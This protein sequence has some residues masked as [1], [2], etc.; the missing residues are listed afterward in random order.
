MN[1]GNASTLPQGIATR[2]TPTDPFEAHESLRSLQDKQ[3]QFNRYRNASTALKKCILNAVDDEYIKTLNLKITRYATVS[4]LKLLI[5]LWEIYGE[6]TIVD[7][8]S[9]ETRMKV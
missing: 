1:P 4:S 7:L 3:L 5:H 8:K 9:N 6:V 2:T